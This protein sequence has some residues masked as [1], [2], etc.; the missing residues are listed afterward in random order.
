MDGA[1]GNGMG[2]GAGGRVEWGGEAVGG[3]EERE[4]KDE[5]QTRNVIYRRTDHREDAGA[6]RSSRFGA[7]CT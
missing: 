2:V 3:R 1:D 5:N 7:L 4:M 6:C